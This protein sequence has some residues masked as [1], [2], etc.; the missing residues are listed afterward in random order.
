MVG[1]LSESGFCLTVE[2]SSTEDGVYDTGVGTLPFQLRPLLLM[3]PPLP[4]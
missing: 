1:L 4:T 3:P 2:P